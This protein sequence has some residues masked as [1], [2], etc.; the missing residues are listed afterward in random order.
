M[1][2]AAWM[3][4]AGAFAIAGCNSKSS[5]EAKNESVEAVASKVAASNI[6]PRPGRW[7]SSLKIESLDMPG[8]PPQARDAMNSAMAANKAYFTCLTP[9]QANRPDASF[10]QKAATGCTYDH[11][12]MAG[13]KL[14]AEVTCHRG[15]A[16]AKMTMQGS[17]GT[18]NYAVRV[19]SQ[20]KMSTGAQM[21]MTMAITSHRVGECNGTEAK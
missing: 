3:S 18:D 20:T 2:F 6:K 13:G 21:N 4:L 17:Y 19:S 9:A 8:V 11:F 14:D 1:R 5:V 16:P 12:T 7:E 15:P 10:F